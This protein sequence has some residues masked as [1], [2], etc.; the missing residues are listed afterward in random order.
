MHAGELQRVEEWIPPAVSGHVDP[1][2]LALAK[3]AVERRVSA[4]VFCETRALCERYAWNVALALPEGTA[5]EQEVSEPFYHLTCCLRTAR[6]YLAHT[7]HLR[8]WRQRTLRGGW[9]AW[10]VVG[11][12]GM[13]WWTT[14]KPPHAT[15]CTPRCPACCIKAA[16]STTPACRPPSD[17]YVYARPLLPLSL[18]LDH[19]CDVHLALSYCARVHA[20]AVE[21][22]YRS[23]AIRVL[24]CTSTLAAGVNLPAHTVI[25]RSLKQGMNWLSSSTYRQMAGRAGR[26]GQSA[27][28]QSFLLADDNQLSAVRE[29]ML[30]ALPRVTSQLLPASASA[31]STSDCASASKPSG[32]QSLLLQVG[33]H[34][35]A[36]CCSV[37]PRVSTQSPRAPLGVCGEPRR[38]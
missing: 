30:G 33:L 4:L 28:G 18:D 19:G 6:P 32:V 35:H 21:A 27:E 24:C 12:R 25:V 8:F 1:R 16:P 2:V 13:R 37:T 34:S 38:D 29:L 9:G 26:K 14:P 20:Q 11:R 10:C 22:G 3:E 15:R 36:P 5:Q 23:G 7:S 31:P 17:T